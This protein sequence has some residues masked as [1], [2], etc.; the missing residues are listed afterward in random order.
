MEERFDIIVNMKTPHG[1]V[2]I[3]NF[4]IGDESDFAVDTFRTLS[5]EDNQTDTVLRLDLVK[6]GI[7]QTVHEIVGTKGCT[8]DQYVKNCKII[9]RDVFKFLAL[10]RP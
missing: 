7:D 6:R 5:G 10:E 4:F 2:E 1:I 3:G 8:L 9:A